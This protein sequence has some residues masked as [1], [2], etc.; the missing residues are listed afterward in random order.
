MTPKLLIIRGSRLNGTQIARNRTRCASTRKAEV[1]PIPTSRLGGNIRRSR[2]VI[3]GNSDRAILDVR[4]DAVRL[5]SVPVNWHDL[6]DKKYT[7]P[8]P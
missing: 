1:Q 2:N 3:G 5:L 4:H 7:A 6:E 8:I